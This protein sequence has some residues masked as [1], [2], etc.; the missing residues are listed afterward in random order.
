MRSAILKDAQSETGVFGTVITG[1][2]HRAQRSTID[3]AASWQKR[4]CAGVL[5]AQ[6]CNGRRLR[7]RRLDRKQAPENS[8][9]DCALDRGL[10]INPRSIESQ[11]RGGIGF[12]LTQLMANGAI[13]LRHIQ[14]HIMAQTRSPLLRLALLPTQHDLNSRR[15]K[16]QTA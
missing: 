3:A 4:S 9:S 5:E 11:F 2:G 13:T 7:C 12:G 16:I 14:S 10:V 6:C 8:S 15:M 1:A